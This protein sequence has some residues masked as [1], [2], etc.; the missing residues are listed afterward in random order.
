MA[1]LVDGIYHDEIIM[2]RLKDELET[3]RP[4]PPAPS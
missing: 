1:I 4:I 3:A 2:A